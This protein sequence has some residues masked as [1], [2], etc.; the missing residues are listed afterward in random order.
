MAH[1]VQLKGVRK[2]RGK[3]RKKI[4]QGG[5][6]VQLTIKREQVKQEPVQ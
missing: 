4:K 3:H 6:S 1:K 2:N 5:G